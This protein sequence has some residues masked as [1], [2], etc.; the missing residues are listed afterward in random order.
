MRSQSSEPATNS[1]ASAGATED[2]SPVTG[3]PET[4]FGRKGMSATAPSGVLSTASRTASAP[5]SSPSPSATAPGMRGTPL[6]RL[7]STPLRPRTARS[8]AEGSGGGVPSPTLS[9][10]SSATPAMTATARSSSSGVADGSG[11][12]S[13]VGVCA[14]SG[15]AVSATA[16]GR[17]GESEMMATGTEGLVVRASAVCCVWSAHACCATSVST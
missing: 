12:A 3:G 9:P 17:G 15:D 7:R 13:S 1:S 8:S 2:E 6:Q 5:R 11:V 10:L 4:M 16:C 14:G